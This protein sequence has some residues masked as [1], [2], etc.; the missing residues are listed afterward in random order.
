MTG[1]GEGGAA[2]L[3]HHTDG[4]S[5]G[6]QVFRGQVDLSRGRKMMSWECSAGLSESP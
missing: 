6:L 5:Q 1:D 2:V 4:T 3:G